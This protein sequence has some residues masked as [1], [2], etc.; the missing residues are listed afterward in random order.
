VH[1]TGGR[2]NVFGFFVAVAALFFFGLAISFFSY[3]YLSIFI[4]TA[5]PIS[6][7][8]ALFLAFSSNKVECF[9]TYDFLSLAEG[10]EIFQY[11]DLLDKS[12]YDWSIF[13]NVTH[14]FYL[15]A[16]L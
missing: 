6:V 14:H 16:R 3:A 10:T 13:K 12:F 9:V 8:W 4:F 7:S 15:F 2:I 5:I 11:C 1:A